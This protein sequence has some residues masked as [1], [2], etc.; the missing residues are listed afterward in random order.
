MTT[1]TT[2]VTKVIPINIW[3]LQLLLK[4]VMSILL[5][6][7]VHWIHIMLMCSFSLLLCCIPKK[8]GWL[9]ELT[10][11][12][13]IWWLW[14]FLSFVWVWKLSRNFNKKSRDWWVMDNTEWGLRIRYWKISKDGLV[15]KTEF[16]SQL[17]LLAKRRIH[18]KL[19]KGQKWQNL[20]RE[21]YVKSTNLG[22]NIWK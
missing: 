16:I 12:C 21:F 10:V 14:R 7:T 11:R 17:K 3:I 4:L 18:V 1:F 19:L 22:M 6:V 13:V 9:K 2:H 20:V 5:L 15:C 8:Y